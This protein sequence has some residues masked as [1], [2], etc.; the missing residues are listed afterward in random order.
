MRERSIRSRTNDGIE[1]DALVPSG[2]HRGLD[3]A[4]HVPFADAFANA[5][6]RGGRDIR[7]PPGSL[8]Q[9]LDLCGVLD[10]TRL[11]HHALG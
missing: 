5:A 11:L 8:P 6:K 4:C 3:D 1:C 7:Q 9:R 2:A 10:Q